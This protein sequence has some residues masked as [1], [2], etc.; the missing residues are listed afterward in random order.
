MTEEI[1][2]RVLNLDSDQ[3]DPVVQAVLNDDSATATGDLSCEPTGAQSMGAGTLAILKVAGQARTTA[4]E[5]SWSA[6][7]KAMDTGG[8]S[9][10]SNNTPRIEINA[11]ES[12]LFDGKDIGVRAARCYRIDRLAG[13]EVWLW[14]EDL[15]DWIGPPWSVRDYERASEAVGRFSG[16]WSTRDLPSA[17]FLKSNTTAGRFTLEKMATGF[18]E[19]QPGV[20]PDPLM[21]RVLPETTYKAA[22]KVASIT[23]KASPVLEASQEIFSHGDC[24]PRNLFLS[25]EGAA[26]KEIVAFDLAAVGAGYLGTDIGTLVGSGLSWGQDEFRMVVSSEKKF[27][28][29]FLSGLIHG[30]WQ[31]DPDVARF[32]FLFLVCRYGLGI[33]GGSIMIGNR[34]TRRDFFMKRTGEDSLEEAFEAYASRL[35][36]LE[37]LAEELESLAE[38]L[39]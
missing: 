18:M 10:L 6:V 34:G 1:I 30:G 20:D 14:I 39:Q 11:Y 33:V 22:L 38:R 35:P 7:V 9:T 2:S 21:K 8:T 13:D 16:F 4:G 32:N 23:D 31:G 24:H 26:V 28:R 3:L 15:S 12:D 27:Y 25:P 29:V 5:K 37:P 19:L 36:I 17:S